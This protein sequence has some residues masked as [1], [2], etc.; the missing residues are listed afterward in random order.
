MPLKEL[1]SS[2]YSQITFKVHFNIA[3]VVILE[4][5]FF[6]NIFWCGSTKRLKKNKNIHIQQM[7]HS[8]SETFLF[9]LFN[10]LNCMFLKVKKEFKFVTGEHRVFLSCQFPGAFLYLSLLA[11]PCS[12]CPCICTQRAW[13]IINILSVADT[14]MSTS[15]SDVTMAMRCEL[16]LGVIWYI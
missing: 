3:T 1:C 12:G 10:H 16:V 4:Y 9:Y 6:P 8:L 15:L 5:F 11:P 7:Y 14:E 2:E 13:L